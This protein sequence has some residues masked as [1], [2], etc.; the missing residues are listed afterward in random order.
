[1]DI[2][3]VY[4]PAFIHIMTGEVTDPAL[5]VGKWPLDPIPMAGTVGSAGKVTPADASQANNKA[6]GGDVNLEKGRKVAIA[7][8]MPSHGMRG[9]TASLV[10]ENLTGWKFD[11]PNTMTAEK[12][13]NNLVSNLGYLSQHKDQ[14]PA[15]VNDAYRQ[16]SHA[17]VASLYD[18]NIGD[19]GTAG[20]NLDA[21]S[22]RPTEATN[23]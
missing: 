20:G 18:I 16:F 7:H 12:L 17:V 2:A 4:T 6:F 21:G 8:L 23:R 11:V 3:K 1:V 10:H 13:H 22:P 15:D 19:A 5:M 14:W 9:F